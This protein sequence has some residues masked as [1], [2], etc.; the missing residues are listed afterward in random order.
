[1]SNFSAVLIVFCQFFMCIALGD[2]DLR[3]SRI[4]VPQSNDDDDDDGG[5]TGASCLYHQHNQSIRMTLGIT[6]TSLSASLRHKTNVATFHPYQITLN[7]TLSKKFEKWCKFSSHVNS[8]IAKRKLHKK[9]P[10]CI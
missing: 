10:A 8:E 3:F 9:R 6:V 7:Q 4:C 5:I 1:M 2:V